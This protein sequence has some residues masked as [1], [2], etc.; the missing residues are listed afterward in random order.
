MPKDKYA[1][2]IIPNRL[3]YTAVKDMPRKPSSHTH[4]FSIDEHLVYWNFFL[5]FGPLNLGQLYRFCQL[6]NDKLQD[7]GLEKKLICYYA[8][9][10][11][12]Q[13][14]NGAF[15]IAAWQVLY[16]DKSPEDAFDTVRSFDLMPFHDATPS[17]CTFKLEV[18]DCL[19]G[20]AKARQ[21]NFFD[22]GN[23]EA[24]LNSDEDNSRR[25]KK[26]FDLAEY[27]HFEAVENGDLNWIV[28]D[29]IFAFAGPHDA[30]SM[31]PDGYRT[32]TPED[33]VP[34]F[35][36]KNTTLVVRL[37][38]PYYQASK[39]TAIGSDFADLYYLDGTNPPMRILKKF[40]SIA[41]KTKGAFGVHCKAGLGRTGTCIGAF[42]MK[43]FKFTA[44][45]IIGWMRICRPGMVIG[46]QQHFLKDMED[47]LWR[48]GDA[49]RAA[50]GEPPLPAQLGAPILIM[51]PNQKKSSAPARRSSYDS[52]DDNTLASKMLTLGIESNANNT[53]GDILRRRRQQASYQ[54]RL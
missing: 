16:L 24:D 30:G 17:V 13:R 8:S 19:R 23:F 10:H 53:Q 47:L 49:F 54:A 6:L 41:E 31:Q 29:K 12:H 15:L 26:K 48:E 11:P 3:I 50:K 2:T 39:F 20:M 51:D 5:D 52:Q 32:L 46:Q 34:Y 42:L 27:E 7:P 45:E 36:K 14:T 1:T 35:I 28:Q 18:L 37:N 40:L 25:E 38:K 44:E 22:F 33:L 43:H 4:W 21:F 9:A